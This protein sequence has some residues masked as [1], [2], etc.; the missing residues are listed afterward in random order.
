MK[1]IILLSIV[2]TINLFTVQCTN[3][4][5]EYIFESHELYDSQIIKKSNDSTSNDSI[6][7]DKENPPKDKDP[8]IK[9]FK[10]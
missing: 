4:D 9:T 7:P 8:Y 6:K 2:L 1:K 5:D 3:E 10:P